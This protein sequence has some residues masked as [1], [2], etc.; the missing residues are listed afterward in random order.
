M[1]QG[2]ITTLVIVN[3][4]TLACG[5]CRNFHNGNFRGCAMEKGNVSVVRV[6]VK[7]GRGFI[8]RR[9]NGD[10]WRRWGSN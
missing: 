10:R 1:R 5:N 3:L 4:Q 8:G 9:V 7:G 6:L 2:N